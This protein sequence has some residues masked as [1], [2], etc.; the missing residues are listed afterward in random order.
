MFSFLGRAMDPFLDAVL[1][2]LA[3]RA[4]ENSA[5]LSAE[6]D[7]A[8]D[9]MIHNVSEARALAAL[10]GIAGHKTPAVRT[11]VAAHIEACVRK[12]G[13]RCS[14]ELLERWG[15]EWARG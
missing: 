10:L 8:L 6:A 15:C 4:G 3:K 1:P 2:T 5:F 9:A 12:M 11:R 14:R 7:I 13:P